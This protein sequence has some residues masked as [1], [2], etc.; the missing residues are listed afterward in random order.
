MHKY[1]KKSA[2]E[3]PVLGNSVSFTEYLRIIGDFANN[4]VLLCL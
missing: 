1:T 2:A 4:I 3:V